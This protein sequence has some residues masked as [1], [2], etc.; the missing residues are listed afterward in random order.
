MQRPIEV[1]GGL[2]HIV[3][4]KGRPRKSFLYLSL[5]ALSLFSSASSTMDSPRE[6]STDIDSI[7]SPIRFSPV[8]VGPGDLP[9]DT[10]LYSAR[11]LIYE[12]PL[13]SEHPLLRDYVHFVKRGETWLSIGGNAERLPPG[14]AA[15]RFGGV[16]KESPEI[17]DTQ[18]RFASW[19]DPLLPHQPYL[20]DAARYLQAHEGEITKIAWVYAHYDASEADDFM[21][22]QD[23]TRVDPELVSII[24]LEMRVLKSILDW[25]GDRAKLSRFAVD[26]NYSIQSLTNARGISD[27]VTE[28]KAARDQALEFIAAVNYNLRHVGSQ[29]AR[30][31]ESL[32]YPFL[33]YWLLYEPTVGALIDPNDRLLHTYPILKMLK[34]KAAIYLPWDFKY[35][36]TIGVAEVK[37]LRE[38]TGSEFVSRMDR[39]FPLPDEEKGSLPSGSLLSRL[40]PAEGTTPIPKIQRLLDLVCISDCLFGPTDSGSAVAAYS[41]DLR[42]NLKIPL[43]AYLIVSSTVEARLRHYSLIQGLNPDTLV[44]DLLTQAVRWGLPFQLAYTLNDAK[45]F[46]PEGNRWDVTEPNAYDAVVPGP[47]IPRTLNNRDSW[48]TA[49][50]RIAQVAARPEAVGVVQ[51]GS[52]LGRIVTHF[53][54]ANLMSKVLDG[55]STRAHQTQYGNAWG[56]TLYSDAPSPSVIAILLGTVEGD[57]TYGNK[58]WFPPLD[59]VDKYLT[60]GLDWT[61]IC[62]KWFQERVELCAAQS[63]PNARP[64][65]R[66]RWAWI[67]KKRVRQRAA[68]RAKILPTQDDVQNLLARYGEECSHSWEGFVNLERLKVIVVRGRGVSLNS[69]A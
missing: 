6:G 19:Y 51:R 68:M 15:A 54:P 24:S 28:L 56:R 58:T 25:L 46:H 9:V 4:Y 13:F 27:A 66:A 1:P 22:P 35:R 47:Y 53:G 62:E 43:Y 36:P 44:T 11:D 26:L 37:G 12:V 31:L 41:S 16:A 67:L 40:T 65:T 59:L 69:A 63:S 5:I 18:Y 57:S 21:D 8:D 32:Y 17:T 55:P 3:D 45:E 34:D 23:R 20:P 61:S 64:L 10:P 14:A 29:T 30:R 2:D 42:W 48:D 33:R 52:L 49:V 38:M 60:G 7:D 39:S 50:A